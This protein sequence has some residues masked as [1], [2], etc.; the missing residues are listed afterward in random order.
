M[1]QIRI[2]KFSISTDC[3]SLIMKWA[4]LNFPCFWQE[5]VHLFGP[6]P[7]VEYMLLSNLEYSKHPV[8]QVKLNSRTTLNSEI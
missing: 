5:V 7:T 4:A 3:K 6:N 2:V 1:L 8:R